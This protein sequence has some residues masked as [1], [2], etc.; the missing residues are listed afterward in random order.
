[1]HSLGI[2][3]GSASAELEDDETRQHLQ[4]RLKLVF[5][6]LFG[7][8]CF[9]AL[10]QLTAA[11]LATQ[12]V[13]Q[14][15]LIPLSTVAIGIGNGAL[16]LRCRLGRRSLR[17]LWLLDAIASAITCWMIAASFSRVQPPNEASISLMLGVTYVM[18]SR[19]LLLPSSMRRT[20]LICALSLLPSVA[21][22]TWLR[23]T[24]L[25]RPAEASDW[26]AQGYL[27]ARSLAVTTFLAAL[28]SNVIYGLRRKVSEIARVGQYVLREKIGEGGMGVVYRATH[29]LLRRE[30][31][32]KM[33]LPGQVSAG[34]LLRFEREVKLTA[35]LTHQ[36]TV[37]VYDYGR[38]PEGVFYYAMEYLEG[39]DLE[40]LVAYAGR[41]E[42]GRAIWILEQVCRALSE[43]HGLGLVHRDIKPSNVLLCERGHEGDVAKLLDFGLVMN[44]KA[45]PAGAPG[46][47]VALEGTPLFIA[48]ES[49]K[50]PSDVGPA[51]DLYS[52][53]AVAFFLL[54][55]QPPFGGS[56]IVE[57]CAAHMYTAPSAP[58]E[59]A[60]VS[61]ALDAVVL[62]CLAK[63]PSA[64]FASALALRDALLACPEASAWSAGS[65]AAWWQLHRPRFAAA[66]RRTP[67][68]GHSDTEQARRA[69]A[70]GALRIDFE[71]RTPKE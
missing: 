67:R 71:H 51:S 47:S 49:I 46:T 10:S 16:A 6:V 23:V 42:P 20:L 70:E 8:S 62:R 5:S 40:R 63:E 61:P 7:V 60:N 9:Y 38:T 29:A 52:L 43:A 4:R 66:E 32:V 25:G 28:A 44:L 3:I 58:S 45:Q 50:S 12:P 21:V 56:S 35:Q 17:E 54:T 41:L 15:L 30:T 53:G 57:V 39:G 34:D 33:L 13:R 2:G 36:N 59:L 31:A 1:M 19:A 22:G 48:P 24:A 26:L 27:V 69:E 18:M 37:A 14:S 55:G 11:L 68:R 65:A 64:R